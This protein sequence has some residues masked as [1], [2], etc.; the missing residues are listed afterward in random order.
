MPTV[1][2]TDVCFYL[3]RYCFRP[4]IERKLQVL[5]SAG[6]NRETFCTANT[7]RLGVSVFH[8]Y[9]IVTAVIISE[10]TKLFRLISRFDFFPRDLPKQTGFAPFSSLFL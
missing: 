7:T 2:Q 4:L 3:D 1:P 9:Y 8:Y 6:L 5:S 10:D